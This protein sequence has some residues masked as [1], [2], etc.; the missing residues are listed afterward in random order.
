MG[1]VVIMGTWEVNMGGFST[2]FCVVGSDVIQRK[3]KRRTGS[4]PIQI[5]NE[6]IGFD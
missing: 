2:L 4:A 5:R 3:Y 1:R 6:N